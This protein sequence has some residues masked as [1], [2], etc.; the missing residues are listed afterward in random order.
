MHRQFSDDLN[1]I[2]RVLL[3]VKGDIH[4]VINCRKEMILNK[5]EYKY[6]IL[7]HDANKHRYV[8]RMSQ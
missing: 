4:S 3:V 7:Y 2:T 8:L 5:V 6:Q 1:S